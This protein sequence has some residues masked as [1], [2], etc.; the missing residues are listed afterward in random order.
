MEMSFL[1]DNG[2]KAW[3]GVGRSC[4]KNTYEVGRTFSNTVRKAKQSKQSL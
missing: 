3:R 4:T 2:L 1:S